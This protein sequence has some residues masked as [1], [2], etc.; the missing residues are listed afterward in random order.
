MTAGELI[1]KLGDHDPEAR[2]V[3]DVGPEPHTIEVAESMLA[4]GNEV[5]GLAETGTV[6]PALIGGESMVVISP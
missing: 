1:R 3:F 2:V 4:F 6:E 5:A